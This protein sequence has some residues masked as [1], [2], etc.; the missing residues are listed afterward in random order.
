MNFVNILDADHNK[1]KSQKDR[2]VNVRYQPYKIVQN[3]QKIVQVSK[4]KPVEHKTIASKNSPESKIRIHALKEGVQVPL[5]QRRVYGAAFK[6]IHLKKNLNNSSN[7]IS[8]TRQSQS[9]KANDSS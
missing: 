6:P 2:V 3:P 7:N 8:K 5:Q 4:Q 1:S 9:S